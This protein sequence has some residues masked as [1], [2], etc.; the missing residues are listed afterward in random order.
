V[1]TTEPDFRR[2]ALGDPPNPLEHI[3]HLFRHTSRRIWLGVVGLAILVAAAV[4]WMAVARQTVIDEGQAV[5]VPP[6][7]TFTAGAFQSGIVSAV[8][9][10]PQEPVQEGQTLAEVRVPT[11][12]RVTSVRSPIAGRVL[13]VDARVGETAAAGSPMFRLTPTGTEPMAIALYPATDTNELDIGQPVSVVINGVPPDR[14]GEAIGRVWSIE[15]LP[16]SEQRLR[17]LTGDGSLLGLIRR[18]GAVREVRV[19]LVRGRTP[20]GLSW[21]GGHGPP[22][23]VPVGVHAVTR[24]ETGSETLLGKAFGR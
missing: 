13:D 2:R 15:P 10:G 4:L 14:Y 9:V 17:E 16:A 8:L 5:M 18:Y 23:P 19:A 21:T 12:G 20:S 3:D 11:T 1:S 6:E 7:G 22:E 24:I